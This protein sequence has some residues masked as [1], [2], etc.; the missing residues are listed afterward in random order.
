MGW[1][2]P[3]GVQGEESIWLSG[4]KDTYEGERK[5]KLEYEEA[6]P[7]G[8][9]KQGCKVGS[10]FIANGTFVKGVF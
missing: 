4:M 9:W 1:K 6:W 8:S 5:M 3:S 2:K 7:S 10:V